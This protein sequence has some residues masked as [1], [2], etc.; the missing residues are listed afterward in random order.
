MIRFFW[1]FR[2]F[3]LSVIILVMF[4]CIYKFNELKVFFDSERIIELIEVDQDIIDKS[5]D[6]QN[7]LLVG[8]SFK[9]TFSYQEALKIDSLTRNL[10]LYKNIATVKHALNEKAILNPLLPMPINLFDLSDNQTFNQSFNKLKIYSSNF[11]SNDNK[12][13]LIVITC[14][15]LQSEDQKKNILSTVETKFKSVN[16]SSLNITGQIKSEIYM[17]NEIIKEL[18]IFS[19]LSALICSLVLWYFV[20]IQVNLK[21]LF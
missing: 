6:D 16:Y 15:D 4:F 14:K 20:K 9:D 10:S 19:L 18:I 21:Y 11:I 17:Q 2:N 8:I 7:L 13:L 5:L 12:N 1:K 3:N